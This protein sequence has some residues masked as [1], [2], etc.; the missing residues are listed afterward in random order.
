[1]KTLRLLQGKLLRLMREG[2]HFKIENGMSAEEIA[3][4]L[5]EVDITDARSNPMYKGWSDDQLLEMQVQME[6]IYLSSPEGAKSKMS[7]M[8]ED[9]LQYDLDAG[10]V[11]VE[12]IRRNIDHVDGLH[13]KAQHCLVRLYQMAEKAGALPNNKLSFDV[14]YWVPSVSQGNLPEEV[15]QI[16]EKAP[17]LRDEALSCGASIKKMLD[18]EMLAKHIQGIVRKAEVDPVEK[19]I[20]KIES[21]APSLSL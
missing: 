16:V 3:K 5:A 17:E 11:S 9:L 8:L 15:F 7:G 13:L 21:S 10:T 20:R 2:A 6:R 4:I 14:D 18:A 1:M 19:A 12:T